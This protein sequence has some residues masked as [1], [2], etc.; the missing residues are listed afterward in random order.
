MLVL[1][2]QAGHPEAFVEVHHRYG[3]LARRVCGRYL[4]NTQDVDEAF[5]ETM[6]RVYQ[7]LH[8]F[9]GTYALRPW[10][11]RIA[12]NVSIDAL[13]AQDR[14]PELDDCEVEDHDQADA[15][16]GPEAAYERLIE[17]DLVI[18][19]LEELPETH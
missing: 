17:R 1:D 19:V 5:Q 12:T 9:N 8:R 3:S 15:D 6:I 10:I 11:A 7:G 13:R 18:S 14:R 4:R 16:D 2:F